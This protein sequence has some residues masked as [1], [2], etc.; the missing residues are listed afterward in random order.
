VIEYRPLGQ[1]WHA[2]SVVN[3]C[4]D[5]HFPSLHGSQSLSDESPLVDDHFPGEQR[6]KHWASDMMSACAD[7]LP[8]EHP[9]LFEDKRNRIKQNCKHK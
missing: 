6:P 3:P 1:S 5:D 9:K 8:S 7:H 4:E 2:L